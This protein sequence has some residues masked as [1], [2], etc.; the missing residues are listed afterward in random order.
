MS[1]L[2]SICALLYTVLAQIEIHRQG[3][4]LVCLPAAYPKAGQVAITWMG[5]GDILRYWRKARGYNQMDLAAEVAVS[6]RHLR[7]VETISFGGGGPDF[8]GGS[9][10]GDG[11][12]GD[13]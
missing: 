10:D 3:Q 7:L 5:P 13:W 2:H 1:S 11:A 8:D 6:A 4:R 12:D 9:S